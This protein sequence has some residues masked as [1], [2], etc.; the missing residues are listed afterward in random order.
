M[1]IAIGILSYLRTDLLL[2]TLDDLSCVEDEVELIILNNNVEIDIKAELLNSPIVQKKNVSLKYLW[3]RKNYG[4]ASGRR[5]IIE[6]CTSSHIIMLDDD[7]HVPDINKMIKEVTFSFSSIS[8]LGALAFNILEHGKGIPNR[9][10]I[11]HKNKNIDLSKSFNTYLVI[12]A[13]HA[14][15]T[16]LVRKVGNY[17]DDFGLYGFEEVDL[18]FR[19]INAGKVVRY[20]C[21]CVVEHKKSPD[22]RFSNDYVNKLAFINRCKMAKRYFKFHYY[23]TCLFVRGL[24]LL[25]KTKNPKLVF[26][27]IVD[28]FKDSKKQ[29]FGQHFY[30]YVKEVK[31]FLYW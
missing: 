24:F 28:V 29:K 15:D 14:L 22:G 11:P 1:S 26:E 20:N 18:A 3:D 27:S 13:G 12:G 25:I 2:E 16:E 17:A 9:F 6:E 4:V 30:K 31:G 19:I 21:D 8:E 7:V 10:E 23:L 5:K